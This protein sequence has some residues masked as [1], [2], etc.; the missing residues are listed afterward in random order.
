MKNIYK[1]Q[2]KVMKTLSCEKTITPPGLF[3]GQCGST[4]IRVRWSDDII[5][6]GWQIGCDDCR[7]NL[8]SFDWIEAAISEWKEHSASEKKLKR[9]KVEPMPCARCNT[10][11]TKVFWTLFDLCEP[12]VREPHV[13]CEC[14][15]VGDSGWCKQDAIRIWNEAQTWLLKYGVEN[16]TTPFDRG[17]EE[18]R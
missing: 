9:S 13:A 8:Y 17:S 1:P 16:G 4:N 2:K 11:R 12:P 3:C 6:P 10:T 5:F 15:A 14:G 7:N 18:H